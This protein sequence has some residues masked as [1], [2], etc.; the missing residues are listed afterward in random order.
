MQMLMRSQVIVPNPKQPQGCLKLF[1]R[2]DLPA[3]EFLFQGSEET[4]P[5]DL[6]AL[7]YTNGLR[8]TARVAW[9]R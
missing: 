8:F 6:N 5:W 7:R 4:L 1:P 2:I 9:M 3:I